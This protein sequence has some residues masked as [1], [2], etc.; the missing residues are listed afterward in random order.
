MGLG[1]SIRQ[2][3]AIGSC[4]LEGKRWPWPAKDGAVGAMWHGRRGPWNY[5]AVRI[6][7][8]ATGS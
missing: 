1:I 7:W 3:R 6:E 2:G 5:F 4:E 8:T